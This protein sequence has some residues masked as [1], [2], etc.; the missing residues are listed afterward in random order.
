LTCRLLAP[1]AGEPDNHVDDVIVAGA[2]FTAP[3]AFLLA[4]AAQIG[5]LNEYG[6]RDAAFALGGTRMLLRNRT[7]RQR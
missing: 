4:D 6:D 3:V 1:L 2:F 5:T 7:V